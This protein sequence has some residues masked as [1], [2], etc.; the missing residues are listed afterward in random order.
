VDIPNLDISDLDLNAISRYS[1]Q[2]V[3]ES[4]REFIKKSQKERKA[5]NKQQRVAE[6]SG[7]RSGKIV[8]LITPGQKK[9]LQCIPKDSIR[10]YLENRK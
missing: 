7:T 5:F 2:E 4:T 6:L 9:Y 3:I 10:E 8:K 1:S